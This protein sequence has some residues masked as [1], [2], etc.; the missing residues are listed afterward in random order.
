M[1]HPRRQK[2]NFESPK[3]IQYFSRILNFNTFFHSHSPTHIFYPFFFFSQSIIC[4]FL[5]LRKFTNHK[6][7]IKPERKRKGKN[8]NIKKRNE[9]LQK[10]HLQILILRSTLHLDLVVTATVGVLPFGI[11]PLIPSQVTLIPTS[12]VFNPPTFIFTLVSI[13]IFNMTDPSALFF[14]F[15]S[16]LKEFSAST[17]RS[18]DPET[19]TFLKLV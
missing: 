5:L 18:F 4:T 6:K 12:F 11:D 19:T 14:F 16:D 8:K 2:I 3:Y 10:V 7:N 1:H 17:S 15:R 9:K 13:S